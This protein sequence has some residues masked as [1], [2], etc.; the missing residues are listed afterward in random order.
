MREF[1]PR[2]VGLVQ[3]CSNYH[4]IQTLG[5]R[6]RVRRGIAT[7]ATIGAGIGVLASPPHEKPAY[8]DSANVTIGMPFE[9]RWA[10]NTT[11]EPPY[12][13]NNSSHPSAHHLPGGGDWSTDLYAK[14]ENQEVKLQ[15]ASTSGETTYSWG[16]SSTSCGE[17]V[18]IHAHA[19]GKEIGWIYIAH[20]S[21]AVKNGPIT[22]GMKLGVAREVRNDRGQ[23][24]NPG[25]HIHI[26]AKNAA[27]HSC[28]ADLG[29][30]G[31]KLIN[32]GA[33]IGLLG[34]TNNGPR[35]AC[36][37]IPTTQSTPPPNNTAFKV[38][39]KTHNGTNLAFWAKPGTVFETSWRPGGPK[40][41]HAQVTRIPQQDAKDFDVQINPDGQRL[42]YTAAGEHIYEAHY[43]PGGTVHENTLITHAG[44][45]LD[46]EKAIGPAGEQQ[47]YVMTPEG[48]DEYFWYPNG[49]IRKSRLYSIKNPIAM[50]KVLLAD[51]TQVLYV[52]DR[53]YVYEN[54]W[55]P[56][57]AVQTGKQVMYIAQADIRD[58]DIAVDP[59]GRQRAYVGRDRDG[60][61]EARWYRGQAIHTRQITGESGVRDIDTN[62]TVGGTNQLY[63]ATSGGVH[64][65]YWK[66]GEPVRGSTLTLQAD[67][68]SIDRSTTAD[69]LP[70]V[71]T[72]ANTQ[73]FESY[74]GTGGM[75]RTGVVA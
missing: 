63:V 56:G 75:V 9:G 6:E 10:Y 69:G 57:Q 8:A 25:N 68:K 33:A 54:S 41:Q 11:V 32:E 20:L 19:S 62:R 59:D 42:I 60:V 26:E 70:A 43:Y 38:I 1:P 31:E 52:A 29:K 48:I 30:P 5:L 40:P 55:Q 61:W 46:I 17:S 73:V 39:H 13:D 74:W 47:L 66:D 65:Y 72:A 64:E 44:K 36:N 3:E 21:D 7:I 16:A 49:E 67:V 23:V 34:S 58:L 22:N 4:T 14:G 2:P 18:K 51:G 28:Y 53:S 35:Q 37:T 71:Y 50:E 12:T 45:V 27:D 24:C 15:L